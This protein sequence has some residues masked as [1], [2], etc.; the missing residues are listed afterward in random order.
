MSGKQLPRF[1]S[2]MTA[3]K[4]KRGEK[5]LIIEAGG[6]IIHHFLLPTGLLTSPHHPWDAV[7]P[8]ESACGFAKEKKLRVET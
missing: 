5:I 2:A 7:L 3:F 6:Q 4:G 8:V 1:C